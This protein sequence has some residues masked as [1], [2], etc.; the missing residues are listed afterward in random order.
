MRSPEFMPDSQWMTGK[1]CQSGDNS[2]GI[3]Y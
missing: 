2:A 3:F 1:P